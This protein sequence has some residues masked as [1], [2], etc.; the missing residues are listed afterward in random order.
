MSLIIPF[1]TNPPAGPPNRVGT[2]TTQ[3]IVNTARAKLDKHEEERQKLL[4]EIAKNAAELIRAER[5]F[6]SGRA[7]IQPIE[8]AAA[9]VHRLE[10]EIRFLESAIDGA[11]ELVRAETE[12]R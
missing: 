1:T 9:R 6:G 7:Y 11:T 10:G 4:S 3:G 12:Q 5:D 8:L 2:C